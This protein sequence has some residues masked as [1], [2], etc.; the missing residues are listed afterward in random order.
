MTGLRLALSVRDPSGNGVFTAEH[1]LE[2]LVGGTTIEKV[3]LFDLGTQPPGAYVAESRVLD[4][5]GTALATATSPFTVNST[6][7]R[8]RR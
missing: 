1:P 3:S 4:A 5:G 6:A 8:R 2:V 7:Q